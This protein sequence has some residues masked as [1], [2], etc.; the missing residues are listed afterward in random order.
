MNSPGKMEKHIQRNGRNKI[1]NERF[2]QN[3]K[4]GSF[5]D[6]R[7]YRNFVN[8]FCNNSIGKLMHTSDEGFELIKKFEDQLKSL[9]NSSVGLYHQS[10]NFN[11][12]QYAL[13]IDAAAPVSSF[14]EDLIKNMLQKNKLPLN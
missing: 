7:F 3:P 11:N 12:N 9:N 2:K 14:R 8:R 10:Y 1:R 13:A 5:W 4:N 6:F